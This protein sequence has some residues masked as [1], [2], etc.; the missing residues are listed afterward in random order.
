[1]A[2]MN[3]IKFGM[4]GQHILIQLLVYNGEIQG[5]SAYKERQEARLL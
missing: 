1:M 5:K 3:L 4:I 2:V